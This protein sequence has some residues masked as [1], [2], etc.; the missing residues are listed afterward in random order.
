MHVT[1]QTGLSYFSLAIQ[2]ILGLW[3]I[4]KIDSMDQNSLKSLPKCSQIIEELLVTLAC[5]IVKAKL[6]IATKANH[7]PYKIV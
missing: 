7:F 2:Y 6:R 1:I 4:S 3:V 5:N